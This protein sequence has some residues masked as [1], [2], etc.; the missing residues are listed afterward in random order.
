[1]CIVQEAMKRE[2]TLA[3]DS[4][5]VCIRSLRYKKSVVMFD[6]QEFAPRRI[7]LPFFFITFEV[8]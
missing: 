4:Y 6:L 2:E 3:C 8:L 5:R 7:L 1:V